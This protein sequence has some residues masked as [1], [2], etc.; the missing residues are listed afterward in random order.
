MR[1]SRILLKCL[2]QS[3]LGRRVMTLSEL[4]NSLCDRILSENGYRN[5]NGDVGTFSGPHRP[6]PGPSY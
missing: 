5:Q 3:S 1:I 6:K 2:L 4:V